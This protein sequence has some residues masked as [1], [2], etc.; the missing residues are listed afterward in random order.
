MS[1][2]TNDLKTGITLH[3]DD[4]LFQVIDFQ[5]VKPGK[6]KA[7]VRTKLRNLD[8]GGVVDRT[9]RAGEKVEQAIID[10]REFQYLYHDDRGF[11]FMDMETYEQRF[12]GDDLI[13][14]A[15]KYM[16]EGSTVVLP[17]YQGSPIGIDLPAAVEL[18]VT[19]AEPGVKGDRASGATKPVTV[20]TG[21]EVQTPL[22]VEEGDR[23]M[24]STS[25]G[26]YITRVS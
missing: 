4:G 19:K 22:F 5:H 7:F 18:E 12:V 11:H 17:V 3:L 2:T 14:D 9:F 16:S 26:S 20:E 6:G 8:S 23:I 1:I 21:L 25:D 15:A 24:V 10:R 13:G